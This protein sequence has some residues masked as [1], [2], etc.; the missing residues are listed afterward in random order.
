MPEKQRDEKRKSLSKSIFSKLDA[1][2]HAL[3]SLFTSSKKPCR[4]EKAQT[5]LQPASPP[6]SS[7]T[8]M[9]D[10]KQPCSPEDSIDY[11]QLY[12]QPVLRYF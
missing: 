5:G 12:R 7:L 9:L 3:K 1:K 11:A 2:L 4:G 10:E 8:I 6:R